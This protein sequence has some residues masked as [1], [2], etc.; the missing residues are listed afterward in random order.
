MPPPSVPPADRASPSA[1]PR[2]LHRSPPSTPPSTPAAPRGSAHHKRDRCRHTRPEPERTPPMPASSARALPPSVP[3][4]SPDAL[5]VPGSSS[6]QRARPARHSRLNQMYS[7]ARALSV[8]MRRRRPPRRIDVTSVRAR[9][10]VGT[11]HPVWRGVQTGVK[12]HWVT[13][14][15]F[16]EPISAAARCGLAHISLRAR[17]GRNAEIAAPDSTAKSHRDR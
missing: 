11:S 9:R 1:R 5:P 17:R 10:R 7:R 16:S 12:C 15:C 8:E 2:R 6:I 3:S 4:V 13:F 14:P